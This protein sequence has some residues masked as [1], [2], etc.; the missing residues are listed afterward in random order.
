MK[1][2]LLLVAV[3][4]ASFSLNAQRTVDM[5]TTL[6]Q[7]ADGSTVRAGVPFT[8]QYVLKNN[9]PDVIKTSDTLFIW[10]YINDV[11]QA[12][13]RQVFTLVNDLE[14]DSSVTF[15]R[16]GIQ[17]NNN[18]AAGAREFC[19]YGTVINRSADAAIDTSRATTNN[20]NRACSNLTLT[21]GLGDELTAKKLNANAYPNPMSSVGVIS[22]TTE[23]S[24]DVSVKIFDMAGRQV[25]NVF[26][27]KQDAGDHTE[28]FNVSELKDGV[29][30]YQIKAGDI[31]TT[32]KLIIKK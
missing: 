32:N 14:K 24:S 23:V 2:I 22:Y 18:Q 6:N 31:S 12:G 10:Y 27:G 30:F 3:I 20:N 19:V 4:A 1:K 13:L 7:P 11:N 15:T 17:F 26:E 21:V 8:V 9:G 29:Y 16:P 25:L 28:T 5:E